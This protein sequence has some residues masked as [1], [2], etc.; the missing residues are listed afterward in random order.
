MGGDHASLLGVIFGDCTCKAAFNCTPKLDRYGGIMLWFGL[1]VYMFKALGS[2]CDEYFV[3]ALEVIVDRLGVST[4]VAGAT[5]MAAGSSAPEL[6]TSLVATFLI[7]GV[8][9]VGTIIGSAI[10]NVLV[11]VGATAY[12]ACAERPLTIWKYPL[13]RD[14][15]FYV[16]AISEMIG[17]L[18]DDTVH[19]YEAAIMILSYIGYCCFMK[20][21]PYVVKR[22]GLKKPGDDEEEEDEASE[23]GE[24]SE[25]ADRPLMIGAAEITPEVIQVGSRDQVA[26]PNPESGEIASSPKAG[27]GCCRKAKGS[28]VASPP[29]VSPAP[30]PATHEEGSSSSEPSCRLPAGALPRLPPVTEADEA[31]SPIMVE[32]GRHRAPPPPESTD[33]GALHAADMTSERHSV[34]G[35]HSH[36]LEP[37][38]PL[39][40]DGS[41]RSPEDS[42]RPSNETRMS[43]TS[44]SSRLSRNSIGSGALTFSMQAHARR[45]SDRW[46][47]PRPLDAAQ[48]PLKPLDLPSASTPWPEYVVNMEESSFFKDPVLVFW[49]WTL[50]EP[51]KCWKLFTLSI[52]YIGLCTYVMVDAASRIGVILKIPTL[53][54]G[55]IPLAAGTSIPD[56]LGSIAVA[57]QGEADMAVCN[58]LGSNVFDILLGLGI[59]WLIRTLTKGE[60]VKFPDGQFGE[61]LVD[62]ILLV[63]FLALFLGALAFNK[64]ELNRRTGIMLM[65]FYA[66]YVV[67]TLVMVISGVKKEHE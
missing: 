14:T 45:I 12:V 16:L 26:S 61:L 34:R 41:E 28:D 64:W 40:R 25:E 33:Q 29:E 58:A 44:N 57:Q 37:P 6:F 21:N 18:A 2:I 43:V 54:M 42:R 15:A 11:I 36:Y 66:M 3:P 35:R 47:S 30:V 27:R 17:I 20:I 67:F 62:V 10:F 19:W 59:P 31:P 7:V 49:E 13:L 8:G 5:F 22:L 1:L 9:G 38:T 46:R 60:P 55:L 4:D 32:E 52:L 56:A 63:L 65:A 50:P 51:A 53:V 23:E 48:E 39:N 24:T